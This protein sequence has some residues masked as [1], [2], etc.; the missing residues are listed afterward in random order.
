MD[1]GPKL[2]YRSPFPRPSNFLLW[3]Q[4]LRLLSLARPFISFPDDNRD[5]YTDGRKQDKAAERLSRGADRDVNRHVS[6]VAHPG[7]RRERCATCAWRANL[8]TDETST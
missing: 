5:H 1:L 8:K 3:S 6:A 7:R 2:L 4:S